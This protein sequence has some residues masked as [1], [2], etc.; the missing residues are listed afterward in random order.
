MKEDRKPDGVFTT[1]FDLYALPDD[2]PDSSKAKTEPE[3][4]RKAAILEKALSDDINAA[5]G[6]KRFVPYVQLHEF[7]SLRKNP[8]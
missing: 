8:T 5:F 4:Y 6:D 2:F 7:E 3:P 1:L